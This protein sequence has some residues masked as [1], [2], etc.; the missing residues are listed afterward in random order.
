[1]VVLALVGCGEPDPFADT[2]CSHVWPV[3]VAGAEWRYV[4]DADSE[5]GPDASRV[6]KTSGSGEVDGVT[7][8]TTSTVAELDYDTVDSYR[9]QIVEHWICDAEGTWLLAREQETTATDDDRED[10]STLS[11][12]LAEPVLYMGLTPDEAWSHEVDAT[13]QSGSNQLDGAWL[14]Q[15]EVVD[16]ALVRTQQFEGQEPDVTTEHWEDGV[17]LTRDEG[18]WLLAD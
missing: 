12:T 7:T 8:W 6:V 1:M 17:G 2:V 9:Q 4:P 15:V 14:E 5:Y 16:G 10:V 3:D 11:I 18:R 13:V